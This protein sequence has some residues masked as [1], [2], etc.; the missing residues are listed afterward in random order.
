ML[1]IT[2][3]HQHHLFKMSMIVNNVVLGEDGNNL[4]F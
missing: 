3:K 2:S 4:I 1:V